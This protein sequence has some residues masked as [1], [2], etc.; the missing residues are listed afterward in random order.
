MYCAVSFWWWRS[1]FMQ[2][3]VGGFIMDIVR[4][5]GWMEMCRHKCEY[6]EKRGRGCLYFIPAELYKIHATVTV[7]C[8]LLCNTL[9]CPALPC[10]SCLSR[11]LQWRAHGFDLVAETSFAAM[12]Y[13][14]T[15]LFVSNAIK[16]K[17]MNAAVSLS[18]KWGGGK[19][20]LLVWRWEINRFV[21]KYLA[22]RIGINL[23]WN[24]F[25]CIFSTV[26]KIIK[27]SFRAAID[28]SFNLHGTQSTFR[29]WWVE[30][31]N[32]EHCNIH[33]VCGSLHLFKLPIKVQ[34]LENA[35]NMTS[36]YS[37]W[38]NK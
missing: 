7:D 16:S 1:S 15:F 29:L 11:G 19:W 30:M 34:S 33:T 4:I 38:K 23:I 13:R 5:N 9:S 10:P 21:F 27:V 2:S 26:T 3:F 24:T 20:V 6:C 17:N 36:S 37:Y 35:I 18:T 8:C 12:I 14:A 28:L 22:K 32:V 25:S 31:G